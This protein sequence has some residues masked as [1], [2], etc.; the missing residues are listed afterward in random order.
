MK[1]KN[2]LPII[3]S[4]LAVLLLAAM[5]FGLWKLTEN[6]AG[7]Q[8]YNGFYEDPGRYDVLFFGSSHMMNMVLPLE[9]EKNYG[10]RSYNM[11]NGAETIPITYHVIK[12]TLDHAQPKIIF[13]E[14]FYAFSEKTIQGDDKEMPH[15][16]FDTVPLSVHKKEA[17]YDLY[18]DPS[19]RME[20][21]FD[22]SIYHSRWSELTAEDFRPTDDSFG[23]AKVLM[24]SYT[25]AETVTEEYELHEMAKV[26]RKYL[27]KIKELCDER[28]IKLVCV[29]NPYAVWNERRV[30]NIDFEKEM[31]SLGIE[32]IDFRDSDAFDI[33]AD[34]SDSMHLNMCGQR[35]MTDLYGKYLTDIGAPIHPVS[36]DDE[37]WRVRYDKY[38]SRKARG[39]ASCDDCSALLTDLNDPDFKYEINVRSDAALSDTM[40]RML[41]NAKDYPNVAITA[42][43][44]AGH[45]LTIRAY[46]IDSGTQFL[47][48][49][50]DL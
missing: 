42:D 46:Y 38:V 5:I 36:D 30:C 20:F 2:L 14:M 45:N 37:N 16:F 11:G 44:T 39:L 15:Q 48:K 19:D 10:I 1:R 23:G 18:S 50:F 28:G 4:L 34:S 25:P 32:F 22:F 13:V 6:K 17:I 27:E 43:D 35:K 26:P 47:E 12:N 40:K 29:I 7:Y 49:E 3:E 24:M 31:D 21:L 41:E 8:K 33:Y 9:L